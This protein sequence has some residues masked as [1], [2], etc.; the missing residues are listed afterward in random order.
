M[1]AGTVG[2]GIEWNRVILF[3]KPSGGDQGEGKKPWYVL[4][5]HETKTFQAGETPSL[6]R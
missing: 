3:P 1:K 4:A 2:G 5:E 6:W